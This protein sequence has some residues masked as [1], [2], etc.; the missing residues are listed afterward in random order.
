MKIPFL[1][2]HRVRKLRRRNKRGAIAPAQPFYTHTSSRQPPGTHPSD[3]KSSKVHSRRRFPVST[4]SRARCPT[5]VRPPAAFSV[6]F[7]FRGIGRHRGPRLTLKPRIRT[8]GA[9]L[10]RGERRKCTVAPSSAVCSFVS[11][12][13]AGVTPR[14]SRR[15]RVFRVFFP[16][17]DT[18]RLRGTCGARDRNGEKKRQQ[19][20]LTRPPPAPIRRTF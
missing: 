13:F 5:R 7:A 17:P 2:V 11:P 14:D 9:A 3:S 18:R 20:I 8:A 19:Q 15:R 16:P 1:G 4:L 12:R 10:R 6:F